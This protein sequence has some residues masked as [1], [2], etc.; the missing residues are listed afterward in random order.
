M[1]TLPECRVERIQCRE[2]IGNPGNKHAICVSLASMEGTNT[3][4]DEQDWFSA[5]CPLNEASLARSGQR[6]L[7]YLDWLTSITEDTE[8]PYFGAMSLPTA[9]A[10]V[11]TMSASCPKLSETEQLG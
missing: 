3:C 9:G 11:M 8:Y 4:A 5:N 6:L 2:S 7:R 1:A 10:C